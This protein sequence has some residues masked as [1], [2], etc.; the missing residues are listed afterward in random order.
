MGEIKEGTTK[1]RWGGWEV[2]GT[3]GILQVLGV[4]SGYV[5]YLTS[6]TGNENVFRLVCGH[7]GMKGG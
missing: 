1:R 7:I 6:S 4:F 5:I 3:G 2:R